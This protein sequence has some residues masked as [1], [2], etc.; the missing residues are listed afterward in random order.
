[1]PAT[2]DVRI[3]ALL[4]ARLCHELSGPVAAVSNG[5]ELLGEDAGAYSGQA[6]L[7]VADSA[8]RA[9]HRLQFYRFAYGFGGDGVPTGPPP[10]ELA[11]RVFQG[12]SIACDYAQSVRALPPDRQ[13]LGCN[14]LLVGAAALAR[15]GRL[16][17]DA[18]GAELHL[19]AAGDTASLA[20]EQV[21][22]L[23]LVAPV[24]AITA[25]TV[26]AYFT[27]L[28]ARAQGLG[29]VERENGPGRVRLSF[30]GSGA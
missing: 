14:L 9:A 24:E 26:H 10:F 21:L 5:A 25:R 8:R 29:L 20:P 22:A 19:E 28:V 1:M 3:L 17:L 15:G 2:L 13:K 30:I 27:A 16:A 12:T 18:V 6:I 7:L 4:T 23:R 11:T